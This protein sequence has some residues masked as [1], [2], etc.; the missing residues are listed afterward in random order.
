MARSRAVLGVG[1]IAAVGAGGM[2]TANEGGTSG[3]PGMGA[4]SDTMSNIPVVGSLL[5][6]EQEDAPTVSPFTAA[7]MSDEQLDSGQTDAGEALRARIIQQ[8]DFQEAN[9]AAQTRSAA[10]QAAEVQAAGDAAELAEAQ[11]QAEEQRQR[12]IEEERQRQEEERRLAELRASYTL[13]LNSY[14]LTASFGQS[15]SMWSS[16][17]H[18]G[19]DFAAPTGTPISNIH[20]GTV[21]EAAWAG[22]YGYRVI[23]EQE[24][25]TEV[26]YNHLSSMSVSA[27]QQ[28]DTGD[29][30]GLVG[31]TGNVTGAHLHLEVRPG[32]GATI[33]PLA[34][35]RGK[36]QSL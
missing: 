7:G 8:A 29:R 27:G 34:W 16:G 10:L 28:V 23:I 1:V 5:A 24:D 31:A 3:V 21:L 22:S 30:I 6:G 19:L 9:A 36:G 32:G 25:G 13:P 35:L 11:R 12:E 15:G 33:D 4:A 20:T 14:R 26:W 18:T 2:A 17:S